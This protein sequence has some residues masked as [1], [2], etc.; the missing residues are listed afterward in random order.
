LRSFEWLAAV[1]VEPME[2]SEELMDDDDELLLLL[3]PPPPLLGRIEV[4]GELEVDERD[5]TTRERISESCLTL[6]AWPICTHTRE[7]ERVSSQ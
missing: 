7:R 5:P 4:E 6:A 2:S 3:P 1:G